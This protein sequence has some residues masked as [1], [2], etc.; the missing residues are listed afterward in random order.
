MVNSACLII[1]SKDLDKIIWQIILT[2][3]KMF[4]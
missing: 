1:L 3:I 2:D 4:F